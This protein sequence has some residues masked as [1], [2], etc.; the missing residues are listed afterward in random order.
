[1]I[2][3]TRHMALAAA[4]VCAA[5]WLLVGP[6]H[7]DDLSAPAETIVAGIRVL[8]ARRFPETQVLNE[9]KSRQNQPYSQTNLQEDVRR[10]EATNRYIKVTTELQTRPEGTWLIF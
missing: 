10:L 5:G 4:L 3:K 9:I 6:V 7:G 1:M 8:G 2:G